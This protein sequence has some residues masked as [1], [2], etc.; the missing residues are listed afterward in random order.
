[1]IKTLTIIA[2]I[3][4]ICDIA[5]GRTMSESK[6]E[7]VYI[8]NES[9]DPVAIATKSKV[10]EGAL[11]MRDP[12][13]SGQGLKPKIAEPS[14]KPAI[15]KSLVAKSTPKAKPQSKKPFRIAATVRLPRVEFSRV[16]L[17]LGLREESMNADFLSKSLD[18]MP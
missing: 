17:P 18:Q 14:V 6:N 11:Y 7:K 5:N 13:I 9:E 3:G 15:K 12:N 8:L 2:L 1:M 10:T 4:S 16:A